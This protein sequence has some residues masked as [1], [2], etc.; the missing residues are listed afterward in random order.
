MLEDESELHDFQLGPALEALRKHREMS[1]NVLYAKTGLT[2]QRLRGY[3]LGRESPRLRTLL[4][5]C[6]A[7]EYPMWKLVRKVEE[8]E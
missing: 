6:K 1:L 3:E 8:A 5:I 4:R 2:R 7:L